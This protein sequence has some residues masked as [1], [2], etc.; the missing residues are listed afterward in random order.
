[1]F[2]ILENLNYFRNFKGKDAYDLYNGVL[3]VHD[4]RYVKCVASFLNECLVRHE[5]IYDA[6]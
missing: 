6:T 3:C 4:S 5:N 2:N 1:M